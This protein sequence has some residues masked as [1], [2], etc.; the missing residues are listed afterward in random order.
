[1]ANH[2]FPLRWFSAGE[3]AVGRCPW[4]RYPSFSKVR[5]FRKRGDFGCAWKF[6]L[7]SSV[8]SRAPENR[9]VLKL[10]SEGRS[11]LPDPFPTGE[12]K[13]QMIRL[14]IWRIGACAFHI[15]RPDSA[16][17][18]GLR[19]SRGNARRHL[20]A[21][22]GEGFLCYVRPRKPPNHQLPL[23]VPKV[24]GSPPTIERGSQRVRPAQHHRLPSPWEGG[25]EPHRPASLNISWRP[26]ALRYRTRLREALEKPP[27]EGRVTGAGVPR[28]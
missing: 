24:W 2:Y 18:F 1:M 28:P 4:P 14:R 27:L 13:A 5:F 9:G 20:E 11:G 26:S 23:S 7:M 10:E 21:S 16:V 6:S 25:P 3:R 22:G 19:R 15:A 17:T 12:G 8:I